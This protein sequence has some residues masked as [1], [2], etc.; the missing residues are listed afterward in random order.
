MKVS[1]GAAT[2]APTPCRLWPYPVEVDH[3]LA[4]VMTLEQFAIFCDRLYRH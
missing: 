1:H 2:P 3:A 4:P